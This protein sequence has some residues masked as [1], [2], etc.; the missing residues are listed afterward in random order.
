MPWKENKKTDALDT[1]TSTLTI[2]GQTQFTI[3]QKWII[4]PDENE[5]EESKLE[6][7]VAISEDEKVDWRQN[8][9]DYL[10]YGILPEYPRRKTK[11]R[12]RV[13]HFLYYKD[14]FYR[15]L[16]EGVLLRCL[17]EDKET[18]VMKE[19]HSRVCGSYQSGSKLH[20][21]IKRMG[22]YWP[23]IVKDCLDYTR[24]CKAWQFHANFIHQPPEMLHLTIA[25]WPFDALGL[26]ILGPLLKFSKGKLYIL[27]TT[28]YFSNWVEVVALKEVKKENVAN[29]IRVNIIYHFSIPR[30]EAV[31]PLERQIPSL[32]LA[33]KEDLT[34]EENTLLHLEELEALDEKRLKAQQSLECYQAH[35]SRTFNIKVF[36][37]TFQVGDQVL[38]VRRPIITSR[39]SGAKFTSKWDGP[40]VVQEDYSSGAYKLVDIDDMRIGSI[41]GKFLKRY[42]P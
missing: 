23:T 35:L 8:M 26:D 6:R 11:I 37:M 32:R 31:L 34:E 39:K 36:L 25:S 5:D 16:F 20:F 1:L 28:D 21:H 18:Q 12:H 29:F 17:G 15:R 24:R 33:I 14:T 27:A 9:I 19:A 42:Y 30:V 40:Y 13:A 2:P 41:N 4:L 38:A 3:C 10:C 22:Y 7:S